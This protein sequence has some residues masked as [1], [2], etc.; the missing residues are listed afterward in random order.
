MIRAILV[1]FIYAD[2]FRC[3]LSISVDKSFSFYPFVHLVYLVYPW[4]TRGVKFMPPSQREVYAL[5]L[6][7]SGKGRE[8]FLY[9]STL[10]CLQLKIILCQSDIN[11]ENEHWYNT[12][13]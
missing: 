7:R 9:F 6:E 11:S 1:R 4:Y 2:S 3:W 5:L 13:L 10:N 8:F 12:T